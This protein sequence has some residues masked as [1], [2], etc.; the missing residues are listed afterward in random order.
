MKTTK[1]DADLRRYVRHMA[2]RVGAKAAAAK[3]A[4]AAQLPYW[5]AVEILEETKTT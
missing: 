2:R 1:R 3:L 5:K 4:R